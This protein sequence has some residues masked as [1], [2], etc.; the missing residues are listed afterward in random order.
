ML[1]TFVTHEIWWPRK[2]K[3]E[4]KMLD[5]KISEEYLSSCN[6][7]KSAL[8]V[9]A[10]PSLSPIM[11]LKH[12]SENINTSAALSDRKLSKSFE[13]SSDVKWICHLHVITAN[14]PQHERRSLVRCAAAIKCSGLEPS[15]VHKAVLMLLPL[16][17][18]LLNK[19]KPNVW[20]DK[21][22]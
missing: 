19:C 2:L 8:L 22:V 7:F 20:K 15:E 9:A 4:L 6:V 14:K 18:G 21:M 11:K 5:Y 16:K 17:Y 3:V 1:N 13:T 12:F 10:Q